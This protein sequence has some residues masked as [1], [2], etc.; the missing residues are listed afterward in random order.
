MALKKYWYTHFLLN[1]LINHCSFLSSVSCEAFD[2]TSLPLTT[3]NI[4]QHNSEQDISKALMAPSNVTELQEV[5][6]IDITPF[7]EPRR[8]DFYVSIEAAHAKSI[9]FS[10]NDNKSTPLT[11][12]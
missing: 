7:P 1:V 11:V 12:S 5:F 9:I 6:I 4:T 8:A 3:L 2:Q 10:T